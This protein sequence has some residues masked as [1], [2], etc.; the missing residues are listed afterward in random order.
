MVAVHRAAS[1]AVEVSAEDAKLLIIMTFC[2]TA[3]KSLVSA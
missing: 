2:V 3:F 1:L